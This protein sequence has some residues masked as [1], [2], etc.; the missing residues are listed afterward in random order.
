MSL[1]VL[2]NFKE[3]WPSSTG[4]R[5]IRFIIIKRFPVFEQLELGTILY[6][7]YNSF[8]RSGFVTYIDRLTVRIYYDL[9]L[10]A[11][12]RYYIKIVTSLRGFRVK[13][14]NFS[15]LRCL[16]IPKRLEHKENKTKYRKWPE[17]LG[18]MHVR[19]LIYRT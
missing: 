19:I 8:I 5:L 17:S 9:R 12:F 13:I 1:F 4:E 10:I 7:P 15:R 3:S 16:A 14:A 18:V 6:Y 11:H 2:F